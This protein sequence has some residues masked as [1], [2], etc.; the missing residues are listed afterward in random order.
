[1]GVCL[2]SRG[3]LSVAPV[4]NNRLSRR[5]H[6]AFMAL[7]S[8]IIIAFCVIIIASVRALNIC[9][10]KVNSASTGMVLTIQNLNRNAAG[11]IY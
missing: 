10:V 1:M 9:L 7:I 5:M 6:V 3:L 8:S 4:V 11:T 2:L